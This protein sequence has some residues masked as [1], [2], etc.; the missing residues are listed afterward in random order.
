LACCA[1]PSWSD[2]RL[3][4]DTADLV[5]LEAGT[6]TISERRDEGH[7]IYYTARSLAGDV[8]P[9]ELNGTDPSAPPRE[10][11]TTW[12]PGAAGPGAFFLRGHRFEGARLIWLGA[13]RRGAY[14]CTGR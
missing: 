6:L 13:N 4:A 8:Y 2:A 1:E 10:E 11:V 7:K 9:C 14:S 5:G 12:A 3:A